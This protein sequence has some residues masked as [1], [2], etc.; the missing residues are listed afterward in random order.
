MQDRPVICLGC[1]FW[2]TIFK[3]DRI[4]DHGTKVLPEAVVQAASGMA[5]AAAIAVARLGGRVE[6]W[7]RIGD[8]PEGDSF[9]RDMSRESVDTGRVRRVPGARTAI[10]TILVDGAGERLVVP[11]TDPALDT[12]PGWLPLHEIAGAAAVLVDMRW[13]EGARV[14]L[15]EAR[16][17]GVPA[18]ADAD[19]APPAV[20]RE[21]ISLADHVLFSEPALLSLASSRSPREA[22]LEMAARLDATVL[23]V[24]LG[25]HGALIWRRDAPDAVRHFPSI[26][27][28]AVD[29]LNAGD[30]WHGAYVYG[31]VNGWDLSRRV[32]MANVAA[33]MKCEHFGGRRGAP[34]LPELLER[35]RELIAGQAGDP[36]GAPFAQG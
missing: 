23:G 35:S 21:L 26:P 22:L 11:Y 17:Q 10:S 19:I 24:T 28:R 27:V 8:D 5:T 30:I 33:A 18:V 3:I 31:L 29:T 2:D 12:D 6:L 16:R 25:E 32:P 34:R 36:G 7:A 14:A 1:A 4:P 9:L 13:P 20:L 15:R